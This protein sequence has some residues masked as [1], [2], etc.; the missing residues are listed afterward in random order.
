MKERGIQIGLFFLLVGI[1]IVKLMKQINWINGVIW[2]GVIGLCLFLEEKHKN[3]HHQL[4]KIKIILILVI[5]YEIIY[6]LTGL[7]VGY[8]NSPYSLKMIEILKNI[9][10]VFLPFFMYEWVRTK[11]VLT[12]HSL[13]EYSFIT[14][15]FLLLQV[16]TSYLNRLI[17][18]HQILEYGLGNL[19]VLGVES[20]LLTFLS[21]QG[22][23]RLNFAYTIPIQLAKIVLPIFPNLDWLLDST[24]KYILFLLIFLFIRYEEHSTNK[25]RSKTQIKKETPFKTIPIIIFMVIFVLFV[26]GF[27]PYRPVAVIS[28]SMVPYF[29][30]GDVCIVRKITDYSQIKEIRE[31]DV[32]EYQSNDILIL[33]RIIEIQETGQGF[34]YFTKGDNNLQQ[35]L[36][37][38]EEEQVV[39]KV[40]YTIPYLGYPSVWFSEFIVRK[41]R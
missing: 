39:G 27:L 33:H 1:L 13:L 35:D 10:K 4:D 21:Y 5:L 29:A 30:R 22:G 24:L 37:P 25:K 31:G 18:L 20:I 19:L 17:P 23:Y 3:S 7:G 16:D 40:T 2:I 8:Q 26:A 12:T 32:I 38:V 6:L 15:F 34:R 14:V 11:L 36:L 28:N 41:S 9:F